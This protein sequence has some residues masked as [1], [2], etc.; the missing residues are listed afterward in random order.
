M[1]FNNSFIEKRRTGSMCMTENKNKININD[2]SYNEIE[3]EVE[4]FITE[5][6][7]PL[8]IQ[9]GSSN[10][11]IEKVENVVSLYNPHYEVL[12]DGIRIWKEVA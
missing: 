1:G 7:T 8:L 3:S 2:F 12:N 11:M 10:H 6:Q 4:T 9:T 5:N